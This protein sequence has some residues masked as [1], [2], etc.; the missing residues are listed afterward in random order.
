MSVT[1]D[2]TFF[3]ARTVSSTSPYNLDLLKLNRGVEYPD[4]ALRVLIEVLTYS[5]SLGSYSGYSMVVAIWTDTAGTLTARGATVITTAGSTGPAITTPTVP[6]NETLRI[7]V[8]PPSS[9]PM[10]ILTRMTLMA[11]T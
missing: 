9:S 5:T 8:T 1:G 3:D 7:T 6:D 2:V 4:T 11:Y 10:K